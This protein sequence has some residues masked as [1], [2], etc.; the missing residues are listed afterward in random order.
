MGVEG[1]PDFLIETD[2]LSDGIDTVNLD[3]SRFPSSN[4]T[5]EL[6]GHFPA[7]IIQLESTA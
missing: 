5:P 6:Q 4:N 2:R 3:R 1:S 7:R